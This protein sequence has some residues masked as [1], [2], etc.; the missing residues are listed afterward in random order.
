MHKQVE[1]WGGEFGDEYTDRNDIKWQERLPI[2]K[3]I[4]DGLVLDS[5]LEVGCNKGHNL[6]ALT[7]LLGCGRDIVGVEINEY[8]ANLARRDG[9][10]VFDGTVYDL[11]FEDGEFDLVFTAGVLIHIPP[12]KLHTALS[13]IYRVSGKYILT[14]EYFSE[15]ATTINYRG[16]DDLLW[17]RNFPKIYMGAFPDLVMIRNG[18]YNITDEVHWWLWR[19]GK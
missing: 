4:L 13:E 19:K 14:M 15:M 1:T 16:R 7:Q 8:A 3:T 2:F 17:K 11:Q 12:N 10:A 18:V 9:L 6:L 5:V